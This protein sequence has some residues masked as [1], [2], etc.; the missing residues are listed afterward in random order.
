MFDPSKHVLFDRD[1]ILAVDKWPG[2]PST[3][4][5]LDDPDCVQWHVVRWAGAFVWAVHQ[6][7]ADTSGVLLFCRRRELVAPLKAAMAHTEAR[8]VYVALV[9]G[10]PRFGAISHTG[11]IGPLQ[12]QGVSPDSDGPPQ[13]PTLGVTEGGKP[14]RSTFFVEAVSPTAARIRALLGTGRTHQLRIHLAHLGHPVVGDDWYGG[15]TQGPPVH[16]G[17][18]AYPSRQALHA[19]TLRLGPP[20]DI[21]IQS[22]PPLDLQALGRSLGIDGVGAPRAQGL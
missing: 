3:G 22:P 17:R 19:A 12:T 5:S 7:D 1:G 18:P 8:K 6:L 9:H 11:A 14:A 20:F 2:T 21:E 4:R 15:C 16:V 10:R 13:S